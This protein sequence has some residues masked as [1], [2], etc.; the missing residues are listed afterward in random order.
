M[1]LDSVESWF[2]RISAQATTLL[3]VSLSVAFVG[4]VLLPALHLANALSSGTAALEFI[5]ETRRQPAALQAAMETAHDRLSA[6]GYVQKALDQVRESTVGFDKA[7][8]EMSTARAPGWFDSAGKASIFAQPDFAARIASIR[9]SWTYNR[10]TLEPILQFRGLPYKD[11]ES[12]GTQLNSS[13]KELEHALNI[14]VHETHNAVP[15]IEKNLAAMG[16]MLQSKNFRAATQMRLVML[17]GL[18][19]AGTLVLLVIVSVM[20]RKRQETIAKEVRQ[21]NLDILRT[22]KDGLFLIDEKLVIGDAYSTAL[23]KMFQ[24]EDIAGLTF[25]GLLKNIVPER[26]LATAMKYVSVLWSERTKEN[27]VRSINPLGEVE[28]NFDSGGGAHETHYLEFDFH[29]V[30]SSGKITHVLVSVSDVTPRVLLARELHASQE[31]SQSQLDTLLGVMHIDPVQLSAFLQDS[32]TAMKMI[33]SVLKEPAREESMFRKKL[34]TIF[35]QVHSVKGEAAS[36][37]LTSIESRAHSFE[38]D[39]RAL[40][41]KESLSGNEF[42]PLVI[43]LDDLFTHLHSIRDLVARLSMLHVRPPEPVSD[44]SGSGTDVIAKQQSGFGLESKLT[45]LA[46]RIAT[47]NG[48]RVEVKYVGLHVLPLSYR[49][50]AK[51]VGLQ[52]VRNA[53]IHG[54]ESVP[55]RVAVGKSEQGTIRVEVRKQ[56]EEGYKL[57]FE[58]DGKGLSIEHIK[59]AAVAK[60]FI[61]EEQAQ[62]MDAK[63]VLSLLFRAG[64]STADTD[65][66][67]AGRGVGMNLIADLARQAGGKISVATGAG[68]FTR[69][70]VLL[71]A[72]ESS[73][74]TVNTEM[75]SQ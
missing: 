49:R 68:K 16:A 31:K 67:D 72:V 17:A 24:R 30:R 55:E 46:Q 35:R 20:A 34:D 69:F 23:T 47:E 66:K 45:Q 42:L 29:R 57:I 71:P 15:P 56:G 36:L 39:L 73:E 41:E 10:Q 59:A 74:T 53:V 52:A 6:R 48:K 40:R 25:D 38:D 4:I 1:K 11:S 3:I 75:V 5:G 7:L 22:V 70:T 58:D 43:K 60:Y 54:I 27:L 64:F 61:T 21:Q 51:D 12:G 65:S 44:R 28:V 14:G 9:E 18:G 26:T 32:E 33:N 63:Q 62:T 8:N 2:S 50:I 13:G 19:I 37:G